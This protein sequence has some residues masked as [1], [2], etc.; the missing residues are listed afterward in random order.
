ML[1]NSK[2]K[3]K[4][5]EYSSKRSRIKISLKSNL[6]C[7]T[8]FITDDYTQNSFF[9]NKTDCENEDKTKNINNLIDNNDQSKYSVIY[10]VLHG[11][12]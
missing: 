7:W 11:Q 8:S 2:I 9:L 4:N 10:Q 3:N 5:Q 6:N 1:Y 12:A